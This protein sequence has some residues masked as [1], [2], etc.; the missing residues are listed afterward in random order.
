MNKHSTALHRFQDVQLI[1][2]QLLEYYDQNKRDLE[3]RKQTGDVQ[4]LAYR[5][6][7]SEIMLQQT[8][9]ETVKEY[10]KKWMAKWPT[11]HSFCQAQL[12]D[13][14]A[15]WSGLGYYSRA[16]RL[17]EGAKKVFEDGKIPDL[18]LE[19]EKIP[20]IGPYTAGAISSIA[21][22]KPVPLVDGNV[23]RVISRLIVLGGDPKSKIVNQMIWEKAKELVDPKRP[24]D[25]NQSLMELGATVCTPTSPSC[26]LCPVNNVCTA[27]SL[28]QNP[29]KYDQ[30]IEDICTI[31]PRLEIVRVV[32]FPTKVAKKEARKQDVIVCVLSCQDEYIL[33]QNG[34][35][36]LLAN[37]WD[38]P[39]ISMM[40]NSNNSKKDIIKSTF[41]LGD[42]IKIVSMGKIVHKFSHI[43]RTMY[44][45]QIQI[46]S[47]NDIVFSFD[48]APFK[49]VTKECFS[50]GSLGIPITLQKAWSL[51]EKAAA[52]ENKMPTF[53][54]T[55]KQKIS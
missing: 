8:R 2:S 30:D 14:H 43:H 27:Y 52:K 4:Q 39:N 49:W 29:H 47:K 17:L 25:F 16:T 40:E 37:L 35:K 53:F 38:F 15:L 6:W 54:K 44:V 36:G 7:V 18:P 20:G 42:E 1:R 9:V 12:E 34:P 51:C 32:D 11:L 55:K 10:Y 5:V 31:C 22:N 45:E 3:W 21:F 50:N 46:I 48:N 24:G 28:E 26:T 41:G 19:L 13:V 33:V 23:I